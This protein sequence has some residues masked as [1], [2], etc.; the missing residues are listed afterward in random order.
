MAGPNQGLDSPLGEG[1]TRLHEWVFATKAGRQM[2]GQEGGD[3]GI[4]N[5]FTAARHHRRA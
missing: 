3:E 1:G 4:D 5:D 2:M